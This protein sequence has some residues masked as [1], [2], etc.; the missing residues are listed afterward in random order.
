MR[1]N[2]LRG[3]SLLALM[4][5]AGSLAFAGDDGAPVPAPGAT[6]AKS[7]FQPSAQPKPQSGGLI[8]VVPKSASTAVNVTKEGTTTVRSSTTTLESGKTI[9]MHDA[10][11][12]D[13]NTIM[14]EGTTSNAKGQTATR[15]STATKQDGV[16]TREISRT[17]LSGETSQ[18]ASTVT[19]TE[20]GVQKSKTIS[21]ANGKTVQQSAT[22]SRDKEAQQ[23][24]RVGETVGPNGG[25]VPSTDTWQRDGDA[26]TR[27]GHSKATSREGKTVESKRNAEVRKDGSVIKR[28]LKRD[29]K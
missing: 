18:S 21:L 10:W 13:G 7:S 12:R 16:I 26:I 2:A 29:R 25:A 23:V 11:K 14:H 24:T 5:L 4:V 6:P 15:S 19:K 8:R 20:S 1:P 22:W 3:A 9:I 27:E 17:G 28:S